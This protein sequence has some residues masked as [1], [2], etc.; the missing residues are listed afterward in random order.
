MLGAY[1]AS[2]EEVVVLLLPL[3]DVLGVYVCDRMRVYEV[4]L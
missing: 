4:I 2:W 3:R 1:L